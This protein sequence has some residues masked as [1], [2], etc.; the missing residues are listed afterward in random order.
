M[1]YVVRVSFAT[2]L[3]TALFGQTP[4]ASVNGSVVDTS[5]AIVPDARVTVVNQ[6][7]NAVSQRPTAPDGTFTIINLLPGTYVLTVQKDGFKRV[8]LP[9]FKLDVNQTLTQQIRLE[10]GTPTETV[11]VSA[12]AV[13]V[14]IHR[15]STELGTTI[16]EQMTHELP[17]NGRNFTE[18][19]ILQPG[20]NPDEHSPGR[21]R[22]RQRRWRQH[23]HS[24]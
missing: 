7:T 18:L 5:G 4:T 9:P 3:C 17:L 23:R 1:N 10:V 13:S 11:S 19:L 6:E 2:L 24:R 14:M 15:A 8:A 20:V 21:Q 22:H 12:N 16:D